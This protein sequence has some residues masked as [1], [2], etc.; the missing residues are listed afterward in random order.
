[1]VKIENTTAKMSFIFNLRLN[2][3]LKN[4]ISYMLYVIK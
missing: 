4:V 3:F 2:D 1:M